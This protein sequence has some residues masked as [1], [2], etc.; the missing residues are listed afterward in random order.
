[1]VKGKFYDL[2]GRLR[3]DGEMT[4][5]E[6]NQI[7]WDGKEQPVQLLPVQ[8]SL[9]SEPAKEKLPSAKEIK[10]ILEKMPPKQRSMGAFS[11]QYFGRLLPA[12]NR[13]VYGLVYARYVRASR[14]LEREEKTGIIK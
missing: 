4:T 1:M 11:Q 3:I 7:S 10:L 9:I 14:K 6:Y 5:S 12:K 13:R 8:T 2:K